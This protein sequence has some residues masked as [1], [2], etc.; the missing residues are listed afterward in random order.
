MA[1]SSPERID[2]PDDGGKNERPLRRDAE[3]NR[4]RILDAARELFAQ[5]GLGVTLNDVAHHAGVGVGTVYRRFPDKKRLIDD[6]FDQRLEE[7][8]A[9][10]HEASS[11]PDPWRGLQWAL[12]RIV[13]LQA[14]DR[15]LKDLLTSMPDGLECVSR[16]RARMLPLGA[17]LVA[18]AHAAGGLREDIS[19]TDLPP[20]QIMVGA[21]IGAASGVAPELWRRYLAIFIRGLA[22]R[23][24][25]LDPLPGPPLRPD[26]VDH[27]MSHLKAPR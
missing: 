11:D 16:I 19:P 17:E 21:L 18:R 7:M 6:L 1:A 4:L 26:Q 3:R 8:V 9:I 5:R 15:G 12:E 25:L 23:P 22:A 2:G 27:V 13:Q 14:S 10:M 20:V 24:E